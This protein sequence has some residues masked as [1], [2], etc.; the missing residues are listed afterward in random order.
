[1]LQ[2]VKARGP[3]RPSAAVWS[4][5]G[6]GTVWRTPVR[7]HHSLRMMISAAPSET[8]S[9]DPPWQQV[10]PA[11]DGHIA[12]C[13]TSAPC[14]LLRSH[15]FWPWRRLVVRLASRDFHF[16][17]H[18]GFCSPSRGLRSG[19]PQ[20]R[21]AAAPLSSASCRT[22]CCW[23]DARFS[24]CCDTHPVSCRPLPGSHAPPWWY[25]SSQNASGCFRWSP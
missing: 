22:F 11:T 21:S 23:V 8:L 2:F 9:P 10:S 4:R 20:G 1:M 6:S 17:F 18:V 7:L 14:P 16:R 3:R 19:S 13:L 25:L 15:D 12:G 24:D 5:P